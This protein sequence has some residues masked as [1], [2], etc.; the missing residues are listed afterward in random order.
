MKK[1]LALVLLTICLSAQKSDAQDIRLNLYT[2]YAFDDRFDSYYDAYNY[3]E[4]TINGGFQWGGG[5]EYMVQPETGVE[6]LYIRQETTAP[7]TY[8]E[9]YAGG[10]KFASFDLAMNY[11]LL[12]GNR[13]FFKPG[14][15][16]DGFAGLMAGMVIANIDNPTNG[17][18]TSA[19]KFAWGLKAGANIWVTDNIA[20]KLMGQMVSASQA[21]GGSFYFGTGGTGAGVS[22]YSTVY[23]FSLGGGLAFKFGGAAK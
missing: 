19:T 15:K 12:G 6:L 23:Q 21:M 5:L 13:H 22:S 3:Y 10:Y 7:T 16:L 9:S 8:N 17:N 18:A 1:L 11:I 14:G 4:G 2:A 20:I